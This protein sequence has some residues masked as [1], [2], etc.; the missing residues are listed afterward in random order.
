[1]YI[2]R[3]DNTENLT[4]AGIPI[5]KEK[6]KELIQINNSFEITQKVEEFITNLKAYISLPN[7]IITNNI[8]SIRPDIDEYLLEKHS[9]F[10]D[11]PKQIEITNNLL[12]LK[13]A[14]NTYL[15][16]IDSTISFEK[17]YFIQGLEL[18]GAKVNE[19]YHSRIRVDID[20]NFIKRR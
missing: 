16:S 19:S 4:V 18:V 20:I 13:E 10:A 17:G 15:D 8:A 14:L 9:T 3:M 11:T 7:I 12:K 6:F 2:S 5:N 1:M